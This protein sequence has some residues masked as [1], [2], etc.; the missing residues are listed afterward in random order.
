MGSAWRT[1]NPTGSSGSRGG[2]EDE[3]TPLRPRTARG[4]ATASPSCCPPTA[5]PLSS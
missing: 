3:N 4:T 5:P 1:Q 2:H